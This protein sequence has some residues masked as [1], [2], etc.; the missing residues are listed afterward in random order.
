MSCTL[1]DLYYFY[2]SLRKKVE[3]KTECGVLY[4]HVAL[5]FKKTLKVGPFNVKMMEVNQ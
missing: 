3:I 4:N 1:G 5:H 2:E